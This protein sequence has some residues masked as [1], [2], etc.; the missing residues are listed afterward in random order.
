MVARLCWSTQRIRTWSSSERSP[1]PVPVARDERG[2]RHGEGGDPCSA[3]RPRRGR[4]IHLDASMA[5][6]DD[7]GCLHPRAPRGGRSGSAPRR[8]TNRG[9]A[10]R[11]AP[12]WRGRSMSSARRCRSPAARPTTTVRE[13]LLSRRAPPTSAPPWSCIESSSRKRVST[14]H[15]TVV[16][17]VVVQPEVESDALS[18]YPYR[19]DAAADLVRALGSFPDLVFEGHSTDYQ[20]TAALRSLVEDGFAVLEVGTAAH[21]HAP[22]GALRTGHDRGGAPRWQ[23]RL[24]PPAGDCPRGHA[25]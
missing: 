3:V 4:K 22:R 19:R 12:G 14:R 20:A 7:A 23:G 8:R 1:R 5:L 11:I 6:A 21:L 9:R 25:G 16:L 18:V 15:G 17:A 24:F 2:G 10:A 13:R